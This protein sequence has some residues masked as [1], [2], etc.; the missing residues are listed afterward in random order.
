MIRSF[1]VQTCFDNSTLTSE[2]NQAE[3]ASLGYTQ[4]CCL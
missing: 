1:N 3:N 2:I 4:R